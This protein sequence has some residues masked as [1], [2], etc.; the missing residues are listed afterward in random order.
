MWVGGWVIRDYLADAGGSTGDE[1]N[2]AGEIF[3]E[4][5][6]EGGEEELES[7]IGR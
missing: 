2:F 4:E 6:G 5:V 1:N 3:A 7:P